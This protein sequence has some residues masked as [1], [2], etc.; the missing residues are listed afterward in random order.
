MIGASLSRLLHGKLYDIETSW[1]SRLVSSSSKLTPNPA[2]VPET[3]NGSSSEFSLTLGG[4]LAGL[5]MGVELGV[6]KSLMD[7][8]REAEGGGSRPIADDPG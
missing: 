3:L 4:I 7:I 2:P 8:S 5:G 1:R 6:G